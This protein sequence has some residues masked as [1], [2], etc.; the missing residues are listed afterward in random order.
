MEAKAQM[1]ML[2]EHLSLRLQID[3]AGM[4]MVLQAADRCCKD[5]GGVTSCKR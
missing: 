3:A 1:K 4:K 2:S 5:E